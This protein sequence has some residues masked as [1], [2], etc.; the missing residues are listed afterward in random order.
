M[1]TKPTKSPLEVLSDEQ[2]VRQ[3]LSPRPFDKDYL[4]LK[5]L[6][7]L[8]L[9]IAPEVRGVVFDYGCGGAPYATL[10]SQCAGYVAADL[11]PGPKVD[12]VL[13]PDGMTKETANAYDFVLSTQVLEHVRTPPLYVLECHRILRPGGRVLLTTHGMVVEHGCPHDYQRWTAR[14]LEELFLEAGFQIVQSGKLTTQI[15]GIVQLLNMFAPHL[16]D[17]NRRFLHLALSVVRKLYTKAIMPLLNRFADLFGEQT[18]VDASA[19]DSIY[20]AT[21]VYAQKPGKNGTKLP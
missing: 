4:H 15:R 19:G 13:Q 6:A 2:Y 9:R 17:P 21:F 3:R 14:G 12:R 18:I 7:E 11:E 8:I 16:R 5:D 1:M 20:V 10:F